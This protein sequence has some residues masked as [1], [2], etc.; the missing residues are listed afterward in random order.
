MWR[1]RQCL[2]Q[3]KHEDSF[4][5]ESTECEATAGSGNYKVWSGAKK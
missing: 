2:T 4:I 1:G 5:L 3:L